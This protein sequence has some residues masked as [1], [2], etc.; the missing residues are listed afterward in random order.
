MGKN[1]RG[2]FLWLSCRRM[3]PEIHGLKLRGE[4]LRVEVIIMGL[5]DMFLFKES[6]LYLKGSDYFFDDF[7]KQLND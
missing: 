2:D 5:K 4:C 7:R 6:C 1:E 3:C